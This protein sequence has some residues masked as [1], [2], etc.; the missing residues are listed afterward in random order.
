MRRH[1]FSPLPVSPTFRAA[2]LED[3]INQG[4]DLALHAN[5]ALPLAHATHMSDV[6]DFYQSSAFG[7]YRKSQEGRQKM[8]MAIL[9]RFDAVMKQING[10]GKVLAGRR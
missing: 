10:L 3:L 4:A 2:Y 9:L 8:A 5:T 1:D 6:A 7:N